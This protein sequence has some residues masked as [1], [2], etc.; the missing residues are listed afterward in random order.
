MKVFLFTW[1]AITFLVFITACSSNRADR[2]CIGE[3][4][5]ATYEMTQS[6]RYLALNQASWSLA[7]QRIPDHLPMLTPSGKEIFLDDL[8]SE[9]EVL[10]FRYSYMHRRYAVKEILQRLDNFYAQ[11]STR[12]IYVI[13]TYGSFEHFAQFYDSAKLN[14]SFYLLPT[15]YANGPL[16]MSIPPYLCLT[17]SSRR[18]IYPFIPFQQKGKATVAYLSFLGSQAFSSI[19]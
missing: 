1:S 18:L 17:D 11:D 16:E 12:Q 2:N 10:V 5:F 13:A 7:T 19:P 8:L 4:R 9:K 15:S 14:L 3:A 6:D